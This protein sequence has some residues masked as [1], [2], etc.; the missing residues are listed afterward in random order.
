M[1]L[2]TMV[3]NGNQGRR[4]EHSSNEKNPLICH[5]INRRRLMRLTGVAGITGIAGCFGG[6]E[7]DSQQDTE[8]T[9]TSTVAPQ[10]RGGTVQVSLPRVPQNLIPTTG[11]GLEDYM[12]ASLLY[13]KM[14]DLGRDNL[15]VVPDLATDWESNEDASEW[16]FTLREGA[17][18]N[19]IDKEVLAEDVKAFF[20]AVQN[21]DYMP[22]AKG[23]MGPID[24]VE[25]INDY[26]VLFKY[27][28]P[29]SS[30]PAH[31]TARYGGVLPKEIVEDDFKKAATEDYGAGPFNLEEVQPAENIKLTSNPDY[32]ITDDDDNQLPYADGFQF[33]AVPDAIARINKVT[34]GNSDINW[35]VS[36]QNL[37]KAENS[38]NAKAVRGP[39]SGF[40]AVTMPTTM[41]PFGNV[42]VRKAMKY[43]MD[44]EAML[45][46]SLDGNGKIA[47]DHPIGP[48][49]R[50]H[51]DSPIE[52]KYGP[53]AKPEKA[54]QLLEE[55]G[56][57]D[58]FDAGTF[59]Y[60]KPGYPYSA[61]FAQLWKQQAE[62]VGVTFELQ[63]VTKEKWLQIW[64]SP[65][66]FYQTGWTM[67]FP[68]QNM[69]SLACHSDGS[70][71]DMKWSN[72][73][74]DRLVEKARSVA[75]LEE[76]GKL[77]RQALKI[78]HEEGGWI[79]PY[80][81]DRLTVISPGLKNYKQH[82]TGQYI[83]AERVHKSSGE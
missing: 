72:E 52:S 33:Q 54:K 40:I 45:S 78:L 82:P 38:D 15:E 12:L 56:Y 48:A 20:E 36:V 41:E 28:G 7:N 22:G 10:Q 14:T 75:D 59:Y 1:G 77:Y 2:Y 42:K 6:Q 9:P 50:F 55:A 65:D 35:R 19:T 25:I 81:T 27:D 66:K 68:T 26:E 51:P 32:F 30:A 43:A 24:S 69:L 79:V 46:A 47:R 83:H 60:T 49:Y 70:W 53:N 44:K 18:F 17:R 3:D 67:K 80:W 8:G 11:S 57:G 63:N 64:N 13:A 73:E 76:R 71:N 74:F 39:G 62:K 29:Y 21:P 16:T 37:A 61:K 5:A 23:I 34:E 31:L 58:G 4:R